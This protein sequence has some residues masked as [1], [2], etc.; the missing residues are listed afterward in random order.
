[1]GNL[2]GALKTAKAYAEITVPAHEVSNLTCKALRGQGYDLVEM[3]KYD[4]ARDAYRA[5]LKQIPNEPKSLG[6]LKYI[7]QVEAK[8][9]GG[10]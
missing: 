10:T 4:A 3:H 8:R 2:V 5:C 6:E 9:Q 1:V 7:D